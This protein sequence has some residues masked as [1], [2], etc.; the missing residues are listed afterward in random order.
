M[1]SLKNSSRRPW[2]KLGL[3][4]SVMSISWTGWSVVA[5]APSQ[6]LIEWLKHRATPQKIERA[7][8]RSGWHGTKNYRQPVADHAPASTAPAVYWTDWTSAVESTTNGRAT[9][10]ISLPDGS[11]VTVNLTGD[12]TFAMTNG[13][14]YWVPEAPYLSATVPNSPV[15]PGDMIAQSQ[16]TSVINTITF[17]RPVQDV[18]VS[19]ISL[20]GAHQQPASNPVDTLVF[21][22]SGRDV[23]LT[24]VAGKE[25]WR[26]REVPGSDEAE[27]LTQMR[28]LR[29]KIERATMVE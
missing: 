26:A 8:S 13:A 2:L 4:L 29:N 20:N 15:I 18:L 3:V 11:T 17:S 28:I 10:T 14:P 19:V 1:R 7:E 16:G 22:S 6:Q 27:L 25:I 24:I 5:S 23:L 21:S 9:G 12:V